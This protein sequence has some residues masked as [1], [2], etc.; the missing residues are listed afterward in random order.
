ML[1]L[2][3][4]RCRPMRWNR[5]ITKRLIPW[6]GWCTGDTFRRARPTIRP[7]NLWK[8]WLSDHAVAFW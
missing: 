2:A 6:A 8:C 4:S 3:S 5:A 7:R 1:D